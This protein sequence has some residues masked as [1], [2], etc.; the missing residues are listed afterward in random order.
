MKRDGKV[1]LIKM[2]LRKKLYLMDIM[3]HLI[4]FASFYS[5]GEHL[6]KIGKCI[7]GCIMC[8]SL[9]ICYYHNSIILLIST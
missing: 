8:L 9:S 4:P 7:H 6:Q 1:G 5:S 3:I 2:L